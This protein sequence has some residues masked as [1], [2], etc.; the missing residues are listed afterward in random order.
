[1]SRLVAGY[2]LGAK[3]YGAGE[4]K[5]SNSIYDTSVMPGYSVWSFY[6][7]KQ[8]DRDW[9][10]RTRIENAFDHPYQLAYGYNTPGAGI[11]VTLQYLPK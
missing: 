1:V 5:N 6:A 10:V 11:F 9:T 3:V 2:E 7:S 4:R 8:I